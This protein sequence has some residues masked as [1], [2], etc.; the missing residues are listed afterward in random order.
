MTYEWHDLVGNVGV[1]IIL[2]CYLLAQIDRMDIKSPAYSV[3][4]GAGS[5]FIIVSLLH[6]FNLSSFVI[7]LAW[8]AISLFALVRYFRT[9]ARDGDDGAVR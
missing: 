5:L 6:D 4:N 9:R 8:L 1:L 7:E 2:A 3:L